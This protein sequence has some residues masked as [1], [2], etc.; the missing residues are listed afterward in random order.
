MNKLKVLDV[1]TS[2]LVF[3]RSNI[4][5]PMGQDTTILRTLA[6]LTSTMTMRY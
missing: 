2:L 5:H 1:L 6:N 4:Y 3:I